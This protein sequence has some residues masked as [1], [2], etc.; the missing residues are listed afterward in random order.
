MLNFW[1][2]KEKVNIIIKSCISKLDWVLSIHFQETIFFLIRKEKWT[3]ALNFT[4]LNYSIYQISVSTDSFRSFNIICLKRIFQ[5]KNHKNGH[6][7]WVLHIIISLGTNFF[8]P[9]LPQKSISCQKQKKSSS[10]WN[11]V[12]FNYSSYQTSV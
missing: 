4:Y 3:L 7:H 12:Y 10:L 8:W 2:K 9:N 6:Y 11:F 1:K 5:V